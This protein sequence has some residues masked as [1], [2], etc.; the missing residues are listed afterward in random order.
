MKRKP[1]EW[2]KTAANDAANKGL[3][4]KIYTNNSYNAT[5]K[6]QPKQKMDRRSCCCDTAEMNQT[7]NHKVAGSIPGLTQ[8]VKDLEFP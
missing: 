6:K 5:T 7:R 3:I 2:K 1:T 4:S 8:W